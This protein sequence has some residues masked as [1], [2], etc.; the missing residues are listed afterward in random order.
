VQNL[1]RSAKFIL[2]CQEC[3]I[4]FAANAMKKNA[5]PIF[6][7]TDLTQIFDDKIVLDIPKLSFGSGRIYC[8][9]GPNGSGKTTLFEIL[10]LLRKPVKG[11]IL[12]KGQEVYP[13]EEGVSELRSK[14]TLVHQDPLLFDTS[15]ERNVDYG[16]RVRKIKKESRQKRVSECLRLVGLDGFQK[17]KARTLSGGEVQRISIA[18]ALAIHPDVLLFDEFSANVDEENRHILEAIILRS[19]EQFGTTIIFTTHYIDQA[20]RLADEVIHLSKGKPIKSPLKNLFHGTIERTDGDLSRFYNENISID[21]ISSHEGKA[22]VAIPSEV[23]TISTHPLK[24][25]MRNCLSGYITHIIDAENHVDL[26]VMAGEC[27]H[28]TITKESFHNMGLQPGMP[29]Y[30]NF[31]A[32]SVAVYGKRQQHQRAG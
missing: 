6:E 22:N 14:V 26:Q 19:R 9:Y 16:L 3:K 2:L 5:T 11:N 20:Y 18:R 10:A 21:V 23:V 27:F 25:S 7:L 8:L 13:R 15:V 1:S 28:V 4:Y 24:S 30:L 32:T 17:R 31:K 29:V 12:F